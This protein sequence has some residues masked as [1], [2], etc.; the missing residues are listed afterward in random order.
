[1]YSAGGSRAADHARTYMRQYYGFL[2]EA[3]ADELASHVLISPERV[4]EAYQELDE[5]GFDELILL[6]V[7]AETD[8]LALLERLG[9]AGAAST[10]RT[11]CLT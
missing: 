7:S 8:E 11:A 5:A 4:S 10:S 1:M 3:Q 9:Q 2:G 6:P